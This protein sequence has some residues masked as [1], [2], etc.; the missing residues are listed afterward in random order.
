MVLGDSHA[1]LDDRAAL[2]A[3]R[4][5][6]GIEDYHS[7]FRWRAV[8]RYIDFRAGSTLEVGAG[9]GLIAFE[10][11]QRNPQGRV[12]ISEF[13]SV[14][15]DRARTIAARRDIRNAEFSQEDV[16]QLA[17]SGDLFDQV[18]AV[19]VLEHIDDDSLAMGEIAAALRP[20]GRFVGS[21]P[22]PNYPKVMGRRYHES[23]G[24]VRDGYWLEDMES[25]L[26][27][28]GLTLQEAHYY[29]G[30]TASWACSN[31]YRRDVSLKAHL[32]A[33]PVLRP[34]G[35][36]GERWATRANAASLAFVATTV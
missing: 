36:A 25:L 13:D 8:K 26:E 33:A 9:S 16:R 6:F 2:N 35:I 7:H 24:H 15:L 29:T 23:I 32:L 27:N 20:G 17:R 22:T 14:W 31:L 28:A 21:V 19:D 34:F 10:I 4:R 1:V 12:V 30:A 5:I 11:A 3:Y 18:L